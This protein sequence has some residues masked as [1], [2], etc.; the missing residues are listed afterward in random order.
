MAFHHCD[1]ARASENHV[2]FVSIVI[3]AVKYL[4]NGKN[5]SE[6]TYCQMGK[7]K[8]HEDRDGAEECIE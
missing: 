3:A 1:K 4:Y 5:F 2:G 7:E 6:E 8:L